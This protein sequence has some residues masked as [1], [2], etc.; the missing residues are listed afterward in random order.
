MSTPSRSLIVLLYSV[1]LRRRA[2]TR[3]DRAACGVD[4]LQLACQPA[5]T[6]CR[7]SS[8]GCSSSS[9]GISPRRSLPT[10]SSHW[11]RCSM[12]DALESNDCEVQIVLLLLVAVA[13][14]AVLGEERLDDGVEAGAGWGRR[15]RAG[16]CARRLAAAADS[17]AL[18]AEPTTTTDTTRGRTRSDR[19][20]LPRTVAPLRP[21]RGSKSLRCYE[22][23]GMGRR[24]SSGFGPQDGLVPKAADAARNRVV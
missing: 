10:T 5:A 13:G 20:H 17:D 19:T 24:R 1:R 3:P 21:P 16:G 2:V 12:S 15:A 6:A 14:E 7:C 4:A 23:W 22:L 8:G 11:S 9:G 18:W